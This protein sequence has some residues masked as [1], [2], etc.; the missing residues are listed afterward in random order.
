MEQLARLGVELVAWPDQA[1]L[2]SAL[3]RAGV[4]RLLLVD[5]SHEPPDPL[6]LGEDW[7]LLPVDEDVLVSKARRLLG[8]IARYVAVTPTIGADRVLRRAE[9]SVALSPSEATLVTRLLDQCGTVVGRDESRAA[10]V[11]RRSGARPPV[12]RLRHAGTAPADR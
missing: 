4:P 3:A 5:A 7:A 12:T 6:G 1:A 9:A 8:R 10:A 11:A 2:R